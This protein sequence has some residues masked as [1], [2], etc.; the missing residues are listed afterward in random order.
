MWILAACSSPTAVTLSPAPTT[1]ASTTVA[2]PAP[3]APPAVPVRVVHHG[4]DPAWGATMLPNGKAWTRAMTWL[5]GVDAAHHRAYVTHE[6]LNGGSEFELVTI[7]LSTGTQS[8]WIATNPDARMRAFH[9]ISGPFDD[10]L[11]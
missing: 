9:S 3:I 7:D 10:D 11:A 1:H 5:Q 6:A 2:A 4:R 8:S